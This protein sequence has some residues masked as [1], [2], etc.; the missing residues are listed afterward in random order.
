MGKKIKHEQV[1]ETVID[2]HLRDNAI[3][4]PHKKYQL[5]RDYIGE[6][7]GQERLLAL[8]KELVEDI[9]QYY[10]VNGGLFYKDHKG[11]EKKI[12]ELE[13]G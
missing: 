11:L 5:L 1:I 7:Q 9:K 13:N 10:W 4:I 12:K 3:P 2:L 6:Q 8:Y